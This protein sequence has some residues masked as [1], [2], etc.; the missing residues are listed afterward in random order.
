[1]KDN[2]NDILMHLQIS[3]DVSSFVNYHDNERDVFNILI[4]VGIVLIHRRRIERIECTTPY[5]KLV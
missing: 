1:M 5:R 3:K 4:N 2:D